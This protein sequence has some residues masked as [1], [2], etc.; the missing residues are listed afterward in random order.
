MRANEL[1][2]W[3]DRGGMDDD[4]GLDNDDTDKETSRIVLRVLTARSVQT[5]LIQLQELD[6]CVASWM[7]NFC[8][9][10]PPLEAE[11]LSNLL[12]AKGTVIEDPTTQ[13]TH[14]VDPQNLAHRVLQIRSAMAASLATGFPRFVEVENTQ[15]L[16]S[17][18]ERST[19]LSGG[20]A[21]THKERRG[22]F[23]QRPSSR[24]PG[25]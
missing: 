21:T 9:E 25:K 11:F 23:R 20:H 15:V 8:S 24:P 7:N 6:I 3:A 18:L 12:S 4:Y 17:H 13:T 10:N 16:R 22:Y 14:T 5:L 19:Y 2:K 1:N